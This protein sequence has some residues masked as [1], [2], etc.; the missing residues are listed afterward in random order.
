MTYTDTG[1]MPVQPSSSYN[2]EGAATI[3]DANGNLMFYVGE[4][5]FNKEHKRMK[6]DSGILYSPDVQQGFLLMPKPGTP[7]IYYYFQNYM[8]RL[9]GEVG[10]VYIHTIDMSKDSGRG[11]V[12]SK[13]DTLVFNNNEYLTATKHRN[14]KDVWLVTHDHASNKFYSFL[15]TKNGVNKTPIV[16]P[17]GFNMNSRVWAFS[18]AAKISP[19][20]C[21]IVSSIRQNPAIVQLH[22]FNNATG[23]VVGYNDNYRPFNWPYGIEFSPNSRFLYV[24]SNGVMPIIQYDLTSGSDS[25]IISNGK[26]CSDTFFATW[27]FQIGPDN[28][29]YFTGVDKTYPYR[30][31]NDPFIH[32]I[33]VMNF[34]NKL[35]FDTKAE[36]DSSMWFPNVK[37]GMCNNYNMHAINISSC[38]VCDN[39]KDT[40]IQLNLCKN[41]TVKYAD[42]LYSKKGTYPRLLRSNDGCDSVVYVKVN[43]LPESDLQIKDTVVCFSQTLKVQIDPLKFESVTL[44][45]QSVNNAF[46]VFT[47]GQYKLNAIDSNGCV[48]QDTFKLDV[49]RCDTNEFTIPNVFTPGFDS[50]NDCFDINITGETLYHLTIFNRWG[51]KLYEQQADDEIGNVNNWNGKINNTGAECPSGTYYYIFEYAFGD[52]KQRVEGTI[53]LIK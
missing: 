24:A 3:S 30:R 36:I 6:G 26:A 47:S 31:G 20:G 4:H 43:E 18:G 21:W 42:S 50:K 32:Y 38:I 29:I 52:K 13:N 22:H 12:I 15:V 46:D 1:F 9:R 44:N 23:K 2:V 10:R 27:D 11:E 41:D 33:G 28:K 7:N 40:T 48:V 37:C 35:G 49:I 34:P 45:G 53:Q 14:G 8:D 19:N 39:P 16:S 25:F 5:V 17:V 51:E